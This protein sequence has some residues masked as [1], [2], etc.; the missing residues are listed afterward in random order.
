MTVWS[1][2][3]NDQQ[4]IISGI[5]GKLNQ[6]RTRTRPVTL[7]SATTPTLSQLNAAWGTQYS[8]QLYEEVQWLDTTNN[9]LRNH[10]LRVN[11]ISSSASSGTLRPLY[12]YPSGALPYT[13]IEEIYIGEGGGGT[14]QT[15]SN[16]PQTYRDLVV[17]INARDAAAGTSASIAIQIN[18]LVATSYGAS[19][20]GANSTFG[21]GTEQNS[22]TA[23]IFTAPASTAAR[24]YYLQGSA[25]IKD[26][27]NVNRR[28]RMHARITSLWGNPHTT[29]LTTNYNYFGFYN[30]SVQPITSISVVSAT[31]FVAGTRLIL[32][33][34]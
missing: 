10:W 9:V 2:N 1:S 31:G 32:Y 22:Q 25:R 11:D 15:F 7:Y 33:G 28:P 34:V 26:Y 21:L 16:I 29:S 12:T 4:T 5:E 17:M 30:A 18:G 14:T 27:R 20:Q 6:L 8:P 13:K 19:W 3:H 23:W 24:P